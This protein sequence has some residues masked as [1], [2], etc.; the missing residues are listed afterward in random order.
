MSREITRRGAGA[1]LIGGMG[2]ALA[3]QTPP[4]QDPKR[5]LD[6]ALQQ[7]RAN[8]KALDDLRVPLELEP[9]FSFRA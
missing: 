7:M 1:A 3:A 8:S 6:A 2:A 5:E 4:E 9:A